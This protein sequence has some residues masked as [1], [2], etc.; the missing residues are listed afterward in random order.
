MLK[1]PNLPLPEDNI[2]GLPGSLVPW[3]LLSQRFREW[4]EDTE[5]DTLLSQQYPYWPP[6][7]RDR[8]RR[9]KGKPTP[10]WGKLTSLTT[11]GDTVGGTDHGEGC[12]QHSFLVQDSGCMGPCILAA[13][14]EQTWRMSK[15]RLCHKNSLWPW[16]T[17][18][19]CEGRDCSGPRHCCPPGFV[20]HPLPTPPPPR[21][22]K[23]TLWH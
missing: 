7:A 17:G 20:Y 16:T 14:K 21:L 13:T 18:P 4:A 19:Y 1:L 15:A 9:V 11:P 10:F 3:F 8:Q 12:R 23:P 5:G 6:V 22:P 2:P